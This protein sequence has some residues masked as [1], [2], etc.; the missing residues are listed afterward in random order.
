MP[1]F[2]AN[3]SMMFCEHAF[4]DRF[5]AARESDFEAVEFL[6][7]YDF[8]PEEVGKAVQEN[9]LAVS[10]FNLHPGNWDGGDRGMAA[11]P[12][13]EDVFRATVEKAIPYAEA[14]GAT[15]LH[16]MAGIADPVAE[17]ERVYID[18]ICHAADRLAGRGLSLLI[19]PIN[20]RAM[21]GYFLSDTYQALDLLQQICHPAVR[22]QFDIFHHQITHGDVIQSIT[23]CSDR[24]GH[25]QIAGVP[26]RH[27]PDTGEL[28]YSEIFRH[29]DEIGYRGWVGCEYIPRHGTHDGLGWF[30]QAI[31]L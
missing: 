31:R 18:N 12:G 26:D 10:V 9:G 14:T 29:M 30:R 22:L 17:T 15:Q 11:L 5:S 2:S 13:Q 7:P 28:N 23:N 16:V 6:F 27:E 19:E 3:L 24:I 4:L 1:R 20:K 21:P 8:S 25:I